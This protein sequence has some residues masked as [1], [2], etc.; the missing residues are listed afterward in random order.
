MA[1]VVLVLRGGFFTMWH[2]GECLGAFKK[3]FMALFGIYNSGLV[4]RCARPNTF[5]INQ[6]KKINL[7][8][9]GRQ[10][11]FVLVG[12][13]LLNLVLCNPQYIFAE[14]L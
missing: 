1:A 9:T 2:I 13:E 7:S 12:D 11:L 10:S 14:I 4:K 5:K 8:L 3:V 6:K